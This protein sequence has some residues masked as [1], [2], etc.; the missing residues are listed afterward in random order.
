MK[1]RLLSFME[2]ETKL[3]QDTDSFTITLGGNNEI[4]SEY[5]GF[6]LQNIAKIIKLSMN[7]IDN[8]AFCKLNFKTTRRAV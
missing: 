7:E 4:D 6:I 2:K 5:L 8:N 3:I 1:I